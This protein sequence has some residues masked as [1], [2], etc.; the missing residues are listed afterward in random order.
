MNFRNVYLT[1][2]GSTLL[3]LACAFIASAEVYSLGGDFSPTS[4]PNGEWSYGYSS[5]L[6][7]EITLFYE[8]V[9]LDVAGLEYMVALFASAEPAGGSQ[10]NDSGPH[11]R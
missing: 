4:N 3:T 10:L 11:I 6:G 8:T 1:A 7:G 9:P 5:T 2:L